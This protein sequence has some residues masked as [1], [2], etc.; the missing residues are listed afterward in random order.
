[1]LT[2]DQHKALNIMLNGENV[3]LSG[4]AG[5]GKS[6]V[7]SLFLDRKKDEKNTNIMVCA[8][9]GM[10][11]L[12]IG[13]VTLHRAFGV[14]VGPICPEIIEMA[15]A[16]ELV[17]K[18][19]IVIIDEISMCRFDLFAYVVAMIEKAEWEMQKHIQL[20]AVG[21]FFQLPPVMM[22]KDRQVLM[23]CWG[24]AIGKGY[25]FESIWW[26]RCNFVNCCL[27]EVVRQDDSDMVYQLNRLRIGD[28]ES[29]KWFNLY[30]DAL[31]YDKGIMLVP[32][33]FLA[34]KI[35]LDKTEAL[36][37]QA[38]HYVGRANGQVQE[39]DKL[40]AVDLVL[41]VGI[42]VMAL[43]NDSDNAYSNGSLGTVQELRDGE[44]V[45]KFDDGN[46]AVITPYTWQV[47]EYTV[48][49]VCGV[50]SVNKHGIGTF[51]QLPLKVA[52]AVTIHKSQ[53]M[54]Y[55]EVSFYPKC[56]DAGQLYVALSR[57]KDV[58][59]LHLAE[60]IYQKYLITNG[61]VK[62]FYATLT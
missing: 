17:K 4:Q 30:S 24:K 20:I 14:P 47:Y 60:P 23:A 43:V 11:A 42:R 59:H 55:S 9:T 62:Q 13:G 18:A 45:V 29:I 1:M 10:A 51:T 21:D 31:H 33:N 49:E 5:T 54:T 52:Y 38:R 36:S 46:T 34:D 7:I 39:S 6:Y 8:P 35:N 22:E 28:S 40:T 56:F 25:A 32:T 16:T 58:S 61:A 2:D 44:V 50:K 15:Q 53:G 57:C 19:D 27:Q 37:G 26:A 48:D 3:F 41:K 12:N